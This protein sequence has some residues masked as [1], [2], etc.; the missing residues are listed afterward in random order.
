MIN[1]STIKKL[2]VPFVESPIFKELILS[3]KK[4]KLSS[5]AKS[6]NKNGYVVIDLNLSK[7]YLNHV[8]KDI[9]RLEIKSDTKKN[10]EIYH[11]NESPRIVE[12]YKKSKF[13]K[14]LCLNKKIISLLNYF[15]EKKPVPINSINFIKGTNQPL[16]SDYI[17]FSS[18]PHKYLAAA[19]IALEKTDARNGALIVVPGSHKMELVDYSLFNLPTPTTINELSN[20]YSIYEKYVKKV[21]KINKLR[22]KTVCMQAGQALIWAANLLHGGK[23][24]MDKK[25]TRLSQVIHYHFENC[26]FFYNP[27]FSNP[28][29]GKFSYRNIKS[30]KIK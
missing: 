11:Y 26:K 14:G 16:H 21:I 3:R 28:M 10:P 18:N 23:K 8:I 2:N 25:K 7:N 15:Y 19:W 13:I 4:N 6:F 27:G 17:H 12:G 1:L 29:E 24:I 22:T 5:L 30:L 9:L 20:Y